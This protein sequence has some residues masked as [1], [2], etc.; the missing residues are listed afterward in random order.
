MGSI[1]LAVTTFSFKV[2]PI[3][4]IGHATTRQKKIEYRLMVFRIA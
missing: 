3:L 4:A 1:K 2:L